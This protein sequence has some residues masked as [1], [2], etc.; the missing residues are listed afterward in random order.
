MAN[1][2]ASE[3]TLNEQGKV[4]HLNIGP[5]DIADTILLVGDPGR[6]KTI[7]N[8]FESIRFQTESREFSTITGFY[9]GKELTVLST[10]IGTDNIDIVLNEIDA[11]VNI[12]LETRQE[13]K[14]KKSLQLI[15]I[16]TCGALQEDIP[17][18]SYLIS[19]Y[20]IGLDGIAHFYEI[21]YTQEEEE[22]I[23]AFK[24]ETNWSE[25]L[26]IPYVKRSN[27]ELRDV[28]KEGMEEGIT[29]TANGFYGP[30]GRALRI[31]LRMPDFKESVR[32]FRWDN[33]RLTNLEMETSG[34]YAL[35]DALGHAAVTVCL[36]IANRYNNQFESN[37]AEK[38]SVLIKLIL[39]RLTK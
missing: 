23:V 12:D 27:D 21:P 24:K 1:L 13:K 29:I 16:G 3:L 10:G 14:I 20:A 36:V 19:K 39:D 28:L 8:F 33:T 31:P 2:T 34:L 17:T 11:V 22:L 25:T 15:R 37:Y 4:Y 38:M 5:K 18:G 32:F 30:Q 6:V 26:N 35:S 7:G 9:N